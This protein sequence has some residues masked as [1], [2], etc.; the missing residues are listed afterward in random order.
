MTCFP[1]AWVLMLLYQ[2]G[3][4][5]RTYALVCRNICHRIG[6]RGHNGSL[7]N[8]GMNYCSRCTV[9]FHN[10]GATHCFCCGSKLRYKSRGARKNR[11]KGSKRSHGISQWAA[12]GN[13]RV[14]AAE[15]LLTYAY[16][17]MTNRQLAKNFASVDLKNP[18][19]D[20]SNINQKIWMLNTTLLECLNC[21]NI[22]PRTKEIEIQ[23]YN[24]S[25]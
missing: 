20:G 18:S 23:T 1:N 6:V 3:F 17:P 24:W 10:D 9:Y 11:G 2:F 15:M 19:K 12:Y 8:L 25:G 4:N 7:Y 22:Q 16:C 14:V 13:G 5:W 21:C